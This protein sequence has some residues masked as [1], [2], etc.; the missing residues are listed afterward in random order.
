MLRR[1]TVVYYNADEFEQRI[2]SMAQEWVT[3][4]QA[5]EL[6]GYTQRRVRQLADAGMIEARK[7]GRDWQIEKSSLLAYMRKT[8]KKG[9]KRGPKAGA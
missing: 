4:S 1:V 5:A 9:G 2:R 8:E 7:F 6:V 3:T